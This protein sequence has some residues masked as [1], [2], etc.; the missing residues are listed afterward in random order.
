MSFFPY[1]AKLTHKQDVKLSKNI[2]EIGHVT[3]LLN[4]LESK[5]FPRPHNQNKL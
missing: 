1:Y 4:I 5:N 3:D 2:R